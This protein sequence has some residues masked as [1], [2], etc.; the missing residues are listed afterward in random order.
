MT[1]MSKAFKAADVNG[2]GKVS[3]DEARQVTGLMEQFDTCDKNKDGML[4]PAEFAT[5]KKRR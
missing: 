2:D 1:P 5:M 3:R 4:E